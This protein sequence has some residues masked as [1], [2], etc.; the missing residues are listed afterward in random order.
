M[1]L[2]LKA[3]NRYQPGIWLITWI[4]F[5]N[6]VAYSISLPFLALYLYE[7]RGLSMAM[8]GVIILVGGLC[9]GASQL[10]AG[11]ITDRIGRRPLLLI[12]V[13]LSIL[14][15]T[16]LAL[17]IGHS[18]PIILI[19]LFTTLVRVALTMQRPVINASVADLAPKN[20]LA[21]AFGLMI[22]GGNLGFAA[23]TALG[24]YLASALD[25]AWVFG[26]GALVI[27]IAFIFIL[28][29]FRESRGIT[30]AR[31][32]ISSMFSAGKD[33][34]L[35]VFSVLSL[36]VFLAA[37]QLSSTLSVFT[38]SNAG[39]TP[40]QYGFLLTLNGL[41][42]V[43]FQY[44]F[45]RM[46]SRFAP[47]VSLVI[48][49]VLY[50]TGFLILTWVGA[51]TLAIGSLVLITT[52]EIFFSPTTAAVVGRLASS[53]QRGRY[54][55]FFGLAETLGWSLGPLI[56]GLLLDQFSSQPLIVWGLTCILPFAAAIGFSR[57]RL[58]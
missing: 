41:I 21:E 46:M 42:I 47:S 56:G 27:G 48:G 30:R 34:N 44:P 18:A 7:R 53:E 49:A 40:S 33:K 1:M 43:V 57:F 39:F 51:F 6:S 2:A 3:I 37:S 50:G 5:L 12:G 55:G 16:G 4:G 32:S 20:L 58:K 9:A 38:V 31:V 36:L 13:P 22:I 23:G 28:L 11:V 10:L 45:S 15:Y 54:M 24:G 19:V 35:L 17:L 29:F 25:Y 52:G 8:I 14:L 26:F